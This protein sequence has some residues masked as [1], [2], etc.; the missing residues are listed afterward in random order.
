VLLQRVL[1]QIRTDLSDAERVIEYASDRVFHEKKTRSTD[2]VLS[3][4]DNFF[5]VG[6]SS[7]ALAEI[8]QRIDD[9]YPGVLDVVD[10]FEHQTIAEVAGFMETKL[11]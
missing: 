11:A 6:I 1:E 7:L 2:K 3:L 9:A 4:N 8:H 5:D 10:L